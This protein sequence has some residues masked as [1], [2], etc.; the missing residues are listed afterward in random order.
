MDDGKWK[1][2]GNDK[3]AR[4]YDEANTAH[5]QDKAR[6]TAEEEDKRHAKK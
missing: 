3:A 4:D 5:A 1:R 2:E 6:V